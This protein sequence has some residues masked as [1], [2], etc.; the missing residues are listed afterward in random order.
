[1][2]DPNDENAVAEVGAPSWLTAFGLCDQ[3]KLA[4]P[5][6][7]VIAGMDSRLRDSIKITVSKAVT[8]WLRLGLSADENASPSRARLSALVWSPS[9]SACSMTPTR[10]CW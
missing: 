3:P 6:Y 8:P 5:L 2:V 10:R 7:A 4:D 1:M 9:T